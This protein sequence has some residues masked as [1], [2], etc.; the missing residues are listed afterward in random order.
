MN[1]LWFLLSPTSESSP[2]YHSAQGPWSRSQ[3]PAGQWFDLKNFSRKPHN[4]MEKSMVSQSI[5]KEF[6]YGMMIYE[7][8]LSI[9]YGDAPRKLIRKLET[10]E[11]WGK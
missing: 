5:E 7:F 2:G 6:Y 9:L 1:A 3:V 8:T 4:F 10:L 11:L